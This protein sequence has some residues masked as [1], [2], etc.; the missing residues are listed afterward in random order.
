MSTAGVRVVL[1]GGE[2]V[3]GAL[4]APTRADVAIV[5]D[6]IAEVGEVEAQAGDRVIDCGGRLIVPGF[7]DTHSHAEGTL[8]D[9]GVQEANLRQGVTTV[10]IGQDGVSSAPGDGAYAAEYFGALNGRHPAYRGGGIAG[11]L[12]SFDGRTAVNVGALVPAGTVRFEIMARRPDPPGPRELAAMVDLVAQGMRDGALGLSTGLD[13]LPGLFAS[14]EELAAL[15]APVAAA[16]GVHVSHMRGGYE[17]AV[18]EGIA[19]LV[20]IAETSGVRT[21]VSHLHGPADIVLPAVD[22]AAERVSIT[23]DAYPYRRGC[24]LLAMPLLPPELL[25]RGAD[26]VVAVLTDPAGRRA[27]VAQIAAMA[28]A[29]AD[30]AET[31]PARTT[32]AAL[33]APGYDWVPGMTVAAAAERAGRD[34]LEFAIDLLALSRLEVTAV[35]ATPGERSVDELAR[36]LAHP[37]HTVGSDGI[38]VGAHPHPRGWGSF[39]RMLARHVRDRRDLGIAEAIDHCSTTAAEVFRLGR[40]G[41]VLPGWVADLA[42]VDLPALIDRAD[43]SA[44]RSFAEGIDDVL[45]GGAPVLAAGRLVDANLDAGRALRRAPRGAGRTV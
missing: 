20:E 36:V 34:P 28:A 41:R 23:Y 39:A 42:V 18:P 17:R 16:D 2:V 43:Y 3:G 7:I 12:A 5:G 38:Y 26:E 8:F 9:R 21:H 22:A 1:R 27:L 44:P 40:R 4:R 11:L 19:E 14:T 32:I 10:V 33:E 29:R 37:R 30:L 13:Y 24:T 35:I 25:Q 6:R 31:W 15:C 45:V